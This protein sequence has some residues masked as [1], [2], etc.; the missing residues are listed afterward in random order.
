MFYKAIEM[1]NFNEVK[2]FVS[3]GADVDHRYNAGLTPLMLASILRSNRTLRILLELGADYEAKS[4]EGKTALDYAIINKD[5]HSISLLK[6]NPGMNYELI[7]EIQYYLTKLGYKPG[8][9]DGLLGKKTTHSLKQFCKK[10]KQQKPA[11]ISY[12]Q[13]EILK[14]ALFNSRIFKH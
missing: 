1:D 8:P 12:K 9:I 10:T 6:A 3:I 13:V 4:N 2:Q 14:D 11:E 5:K 7:K